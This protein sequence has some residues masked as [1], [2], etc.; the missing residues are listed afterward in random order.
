MWLKSAVRQLAKWVPTS[1]EYMR[2]QLRAVRDVATEQ[3][4]MPVPHIPEP[5]PVDV[6][7]LA[8]DEVLDAEVMDE[9]EQ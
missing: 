8:V 1:A 4:G 9:A 6:S 7:H 3:P 2:E 5:S